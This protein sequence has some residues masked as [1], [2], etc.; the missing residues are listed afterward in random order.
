[1]N[2]LKKQSEFYLRQ[3]SLHF[4]RKEPNQK[5]SRISKRKL[6]NV[7]Q[8]VEILVYRIKQFEQN[9]LLY[10]KLLKVVFSSKTGAYFGRSWLFRFNEKIKKNNSSVQILHFSY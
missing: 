3:V 8:A 7:Q 6:P 4:F 9:F 1:M 10:P 5:F 2:F